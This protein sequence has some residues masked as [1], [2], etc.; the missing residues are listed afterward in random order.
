M[1]EDRP[2]LSARELLRTESTF[3]R[4]IDYV[5]TAGRSK[6]G[7]DLVSCVLYTKAVA[8]FPSR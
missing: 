5:D 1:N 7:A 6:V 3:Q 4:N 8:R 2:A